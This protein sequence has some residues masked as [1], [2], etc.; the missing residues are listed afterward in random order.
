MYGFSKVIQLYFHK[1]YFLYISV[2]TKCLMRQ[3]PYHTTVIVIINMIFFSYTP[4]F[5]LLKSNFINHN[6]NAWF[7]ALRYN[8]LKF[9][10]DSMSHAIKYLLLFPALLA[11]NWILKNKELF[12]IHNIL[13]ISVCKIVTRLC[14]CYL[15]RH[16]LCP[17]ILID[18]MIR[19]ELG[20][21]LG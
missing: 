10:P 21:G 5:P 20:G 13:M 8:S 7:P 4:F 14:G 18:K 16:N 17:S 6:F 19:H 11:E 12:Y 15:S 9:V 3:Y 2:I 1:I